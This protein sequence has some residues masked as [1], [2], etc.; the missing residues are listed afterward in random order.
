M[1][2]C[3]N[4]DNMYYLKLNDKDQNKLLYYC[5]QCGNEDD[6]LVNN[7]ICVLK[8]KIT[9]SE[10]VYHH[11]I[12]EY[13]KEDP[14]I[15]RITNIKCPNT[16]CPSNLTNEDENKDNKVEREV[17]YIRYDDL[18]MKYV[19]LCAICDKVWET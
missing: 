7:E 6:N 17:L 16:E 5:R 15:P 11:I 19:Y 18:N 9:D 12:N 2:F 4:C 13:T 14:T 10:Q 3:S 1:Y 8:T